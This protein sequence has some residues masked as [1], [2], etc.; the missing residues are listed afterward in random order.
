MGGGGCVPTFFRD[1]S[2]RARTS[3]RVGI[4]VQSHPDCDVS[5]RAFPLHSVPRVLQYV[6]AMDVWLA[7]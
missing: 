4:G 2:Q 5:I 1:N 6:H 7:P 3:L